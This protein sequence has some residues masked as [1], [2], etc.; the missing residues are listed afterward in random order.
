MDRDRGLIRSDPSTRGVIRGALIGR[1]Q[2][3]GLFPGAPGGIA[4]VNEIRCGH[5]AQRDLFTLGIDS[6]GSLK[7]R[8]LS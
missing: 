1:D 3:L 5:G 2:F 4:G 7:G 6:V 8:K